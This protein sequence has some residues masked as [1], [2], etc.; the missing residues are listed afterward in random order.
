MQKKFRPIISE[1]RMEELHL[2][3]KKSQNNVHHTE[4]G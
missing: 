4:Q 1:G 2:C 3:F